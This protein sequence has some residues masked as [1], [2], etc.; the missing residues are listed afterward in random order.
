MVMTLLI[1]Q[2]LKGNSGGRKA[3]KRSGLFSQRLKKP[4]VKTAPRKKPAKKQK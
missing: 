2:R 4:Q 1:G 3:R